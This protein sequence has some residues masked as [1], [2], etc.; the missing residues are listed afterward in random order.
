MT[1]V[2]ETRHAPESAIVRVPLLLKILIAFVSG[3]SL[4]AVT[5]QALEMLH[6]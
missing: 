5:A 1:T 2:P 4:A 3:A 6:H